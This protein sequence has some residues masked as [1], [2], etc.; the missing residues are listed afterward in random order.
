MPKSV[1]TYMKK[2]MSEETLMYFKFVED[3]FTL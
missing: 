3:Y 2:L 1:N